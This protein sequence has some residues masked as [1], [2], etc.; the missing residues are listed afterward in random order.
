[1]PKRLDP[2]QQKR[3][4]LAR[5]FAKF[6]RHATDIFDRSDDMLL[7][8]EESRLGIWIGVTLNRYAELFDRLAKHYFKGFERHEHVSGGR[9]WVRFGYDY[10][11]KV[12]T[13]VTKATEKS[14]EA[15]AS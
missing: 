2:Q 6:T 8:Q 14:K 9:A 7:S 1:M 3:R 10:G 11:G 15:T 13:Q 5:A 12:P 4:S